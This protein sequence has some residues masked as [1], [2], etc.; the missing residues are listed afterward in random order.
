MADSGVMIMISGGAMGA[1]TCWARAAHKAGYKVVVHSF[2]GHHLATDH[3]SGITVTSL[4]NAD[5]AEAHVPISVAASRLGKSMPTKYTGLLIMRNYKIANTCRAMYA[6][7]NFTGKQMH[8]LDIGVLGGTGWACQ[9]Y[10]DRHHRHSNASRAIPLFL[11]HQCN[12]STAGCD[13][14]QMRSTGWYEC[15]VDGDA[16]VWKPCS[17]VP[18][19][20]GFD[21]VAGVGT[22]ELTAQGRAE[23]D[24]LFG[25]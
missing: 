20:S 15:H 7:A 4:S 23:I 22:R 19:P 12:T 3:P 9:L 2:P 18:R 17:A 6:V 24:R 13:Q 16:F 21:I 1:D 8:P 11:Y 25:L 5:K 10:A 14:A